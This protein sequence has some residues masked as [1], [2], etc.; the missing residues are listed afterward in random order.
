MLWDLFQY[1]VSVN[2]GS[3]LIISVSAPLSCTHKHVLVWFHMGLLVLCWCCR[4]S[5]VSHRLFVIYASVIRLCHAIWDVISYQLCVCIFIVFLVSLH[6]LQQV[7]H[8]CPFKYSGHNKRVIK[9]K[10]RTSV[11]VTVSKFLLL[12]IA[13]RHAQVTKKYTDLSYAGVE[14]W[15][16]LYGFIPTLCL[17]IFPI[18]L[19]TEEKRE[20]KE[21]Y[22]YEDF[23]SCTECLFI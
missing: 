21:W 4:R 12:L 13:F 22:F 20:R 18:P 19:K 6:W 2:L 8:V 9:Y 10:V 3:D 23:Y 5:G 7:S 14:N 11:H 17:A 16:K 15:Q 1:C